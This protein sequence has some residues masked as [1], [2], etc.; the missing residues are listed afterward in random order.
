MQRS[1][2]SSGGP[3]RRLLIG[4]L[5]AALPAAVCWPRGTP[6][7]AWQQASGAE[8]WRQEM[9]IS[10]LKPGRHN[11]IVR[12][13]DSAGNE[14]VQGPY[15]IRIDP[16]VGLPS[17][18]IVYPAPGAVLR[19]DIGVIGVA[20]GPAGIA[21]VEL[22]LGD[23]SPLAAEGTEY[24]SRTIDARDISDGAY[25]LDAR[26]IDE[27]GTEGPAVSV[28]FV[29]DRSPP[30]VSLTSHRSG[31]LVSGNV[32][33]EGEADDAN[34]VVS[35]ELS[36][37]GGLSFQPL[38]LAT[39]R[40]QTAASFAF[41]VASRKLADGAAIYQLRAT[42]GSGAVTLQPVLFY[43]D[44]QPPGLEILN[45]EEG[46]TV[47]GTVRVTGSVAD[48]VGLAR[49]YYVLDRQEHDVELR[50]GDPY[51]T[52][53]ID[54]SAERGR[55][56]ALRFTAVDRSGN[57][58]SVSR[59]LQNDPGA[60]GLSVS[61]T[62][63]EAGALGALLPDGALYGL[64]SGRGRPDVV[65]VEGLATGEYPARPGF[66]IPASDL[67]AGRGELR[68]RA[69][70]ADGTLGTPLRI[71]LQAGGPAGPATQASS[72]TVSEPEPY[73]YVGDSF[74][75][76]GRLDGTASGLRPEYRLSPAEPW[77]SI[78]VADGLFQ[79]AISLAA[80]PAGPV[81]LELRTA[82]EGRADFPL[83]LPLN[84]STGVPSLRIHSPRPGDVVNGRVTVSGSIESSTPL[85]EAFF[86]LGSSPEVAVPLAPVGAGSAFA[87]VADLGALADPARP[88]EIRAVDAAG[89]RQ[90]VEAPVR[91]DRTGD[92]PVVQLQL[93]PEGA[94]LSTDFTISGLAFDDDGV[95]AVFWRLGEGSFQRL[96]ATQD[97]RVEVP[98]A[99]A[100]G[101]QLVVEVYAEDIYG[102]AGQPARAAVQVSTD[103]PQIRVTEPGIDEY[104]RGTTLIRGTAS[105][106]NG[107]AQVRLSMDNGNSFQVAEGTEQWS[108]AL[109]SALY[110]DGTYSLL[111][112]AADTLGVEAR[113]TSLLSIDN[114]PPALWLAEPTDGRLCGPKLRIAGRV[115]DNIL[116]RSLRL[117]LSG[118][119]R[120]E[121]GL[122]V[123]IQPGAV[124]LETIDLS[125]LPPGA[126]NLRLV[127]TD[128]A[129]NAAV[130]ARN[131]ELA[132]GASAYLAVLY[133]PL[134]GTAHTGPL[135][136]SGRAAGPEL[137]AR[138]SIFSGQQELAAAEVDRF[139]FF[140]HSLA[141]EMTGERL[142]LTAVFQ[143]P[144]GAAVRS[145]VHRVDLQPGGPALSIDSHHDGDAITGR[146]WLRGRA[147]LQLPPEPAQDPASRRGGERRMTRVL[148]SLDNGRSFQPAR[149]GESW[150]FRLEA[151]ELPQGPL[152]LL[153][154]AEFAGGLSATRRIVLVVDTAPPTVS[155]IAPREGSLHSDSL[156][157]YGTA[158]DQQGIESIGVNLRP[159]DKAGYGVPKFVQ[160]LYLD[161]HVLGAT[162]ADVGLGISFFDN[163]VKLQVQAGVAPPGRFT[164][165]V[166]GAKLLANVLTLPFAHFF[167]PDWAFFSMALALGANFS[168][169]TM[170]AGSEGLVMSAVLAQWEFARF[171]I[172]A[173]TT[174]HTFS[175]YLEP[176]LWF[177]SSDVEAAAVFRISFG[178]RVGIL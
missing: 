154:R 138:V 66:R 86:R 146:P 57:T 109:N 60:A 173:W 115:E 27:R 12:A 169:F 3:S 52:A 72:L 123:P 137:P 163:N 77:Q 58:T 135:T 85:A 128:P 177:A 63:P 74:T 22:R 166:F 141:E 101:G 39:R 15:N 88:L 143:T 122:S 62:H 116:V 168:Y 68:I 92:L 67:R 127:A 87:F 47:F 96:E 81:H 90:T 113:T 133:S 126:Y 150:Q 102:V 10:K 35:V 103:R 84:H 145:E 164:G 110:A 152:P 161:S 78:P 38:R 134:P 30:T 41:P 36:A 65:L 50:P 148:V 100:R 162:Y 130:V 112:E 105:D 49:L 20:S 44:N 56:V 140:H 136:V 7:E 76:S 93:P 54:L 156:L 21:R 18:R 131:I 26:A 83:Y 132:T 121:Q 13:R 99:Q 178:L 70:A 64:V 165:T 11:V 174:F 31:A 144:E 48:A 53:D 142:D 106:L 176:N 17:A 5:L 71:R 34:G 6:E 151:A 172:P 153:V 125:S 160:G 147:W 149:G 4:L 89:S 29:L 55:S 94:R 124:I 108:L 157:V 33:L 45:P 80:L 14:A 175:L 75:L 28:P 25:L 43:V 97:F 119:S 120:K 158:S 167:G 117:E 59:A 95:A 40:G 2:L 73:R 98:L 37:D 51:W 114:Q 1:A 104:R 16:A 118:V 82:G 107:I 24:W 61:L 8:V 91:L 19:G 155:L 79:T 46:D 32:L 9:D 171:R 69:R 111:V 23:G 170:D 129:G 139:G 159:G 42:D